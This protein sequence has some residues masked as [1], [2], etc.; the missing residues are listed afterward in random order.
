MI[1]GGVRSQLAIFEA[2]K[3]LVIDSP[4]IDSTFA[5]SVLAEALLGAIGGGI[6]ALVRSIVTSN[7]R[8]EGNIIL[9]PPS[10]S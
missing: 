5:E 10:L 7:G 4:R 6:G 9:A 3:T 8:G 2:L 1:L